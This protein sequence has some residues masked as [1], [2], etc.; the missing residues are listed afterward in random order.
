[1]EGKEQRSFKADLLVDLSNPN[2]FQ[3][4]EFCIGG[5]FLSGVLIAAKSMKHHIN[6]FVEDRNLRNWTELFTLKSGAVEQ[7]PHRSRSEVVL[8]IEYCWTSTLFTVDRAGLKQGQ[9]V[10]VCEDNVLLTVVEVDFIVNSFKRQHEQFGLFPAKQYLAVPA[11]R[12]NNELGNVL[13]ERG[14]RTNLMVGTVE[15]GGM[16][17]HYTGLVIEHCDELFYVGKFKACFGDAFLLC[18]SK[19]LLQKFLGEIAEK[20]DFAV[21]FGCRLIITEILI[22]RQSDSDIFFVLKDRHR[23]FFKI[24]DLRKEESADLKLPLSPYILK[25]MV[26]D[27]LSLFKKA[28]SGS[29]ISC[30]SREGSIQAGQTFAKKT[31][32][33]SHLSSIDEPSFVV[34]ERVAAKGAYSVRN[35][36]V[37][38]MKSSLMEDSQQLSTN[39]SQNEK[40]EKPKKFKFNACKSPFK[41]N[42]NGQSELVKNGSENYTVSPKEFDSEEP[43]A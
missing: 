15:K 19:S 14:P 9:A 40:N 37:A 10:Y 34:Q 23:I 6:V 17:P 36:Q 27:P 16:Q 2:T 11:R 30:I 1:M 21:R 25:G 8:V 41:W 35:L 7:C 26:E 12:R 4:G 32:A 22:E 31:L 39:T 20:S 29:T 28:N 5:Y 24:I 3:I 18:N 13:E 43:S 33:N 38:S 42:N